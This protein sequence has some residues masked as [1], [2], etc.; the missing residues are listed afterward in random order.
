MMGLAHFFDNEVAGSAHGAEKGG[1]TPLGLEVVARM[2]ELGI[3]LDLAHASPRAIDD[4]LAKAAK[5]VVVSHTGVQGTCPGPRNLS[6]DQ[7]RRIAATGGVVGIGYFDGAVCGHEVAAIVAALRHA[8][9]VAG[10]AAVGLG[11]DWDGAVAAPF[12]AA[13]LP[14]LTAALIAA[15]VSGDDLRAVAGENALR[16]LRETLPD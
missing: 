11:S 12:D 2:E 14:Q 3:A 13:G 8:I 15:G 1:L 10:P 4:A 16:V 6:D 7:L 9:A 5:P